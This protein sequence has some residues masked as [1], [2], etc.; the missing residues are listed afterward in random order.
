MSDCIVCGFALH[1]HEDIGYLQGGYGA[2]H[3]GG[4]CPPEISLM[5]AAPY[6]STAMR[7]TSERKVSTETGRSGVFVSQ[8]AKGRA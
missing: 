1:M 4:E 3:L 5:I 7:A 8:D 6:S 2:V